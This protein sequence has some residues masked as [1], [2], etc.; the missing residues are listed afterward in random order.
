MPSCPTGVRFL[1]PGAKRL[2]SLTSRAAFIWSSKEV[3][4]IK[5]TPRAAVIW[6]LTEVISVKRIG[7]MWP[8]QSTLSTLTQSKHTVPIFNADFASTL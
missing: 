4:S 2:L 1:I 6:S 3:I 7:K 8:L 5:R